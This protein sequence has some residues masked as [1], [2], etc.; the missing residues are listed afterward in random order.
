MWALFLTSQDWIP[1]KSYVSSPKSWDFWDV[2]LSF[3]LVLKIYT[4]F[5]FYKHVYLLW[6]SSFL[7]FLIHRIWNT[8]KWNRQASV[9]P[10]RKCQTFKYYSGSVFIFYRG[11]ACLPGRLHQ[12]WQEG[13]RTSREN[14]S[15]G[16]FRQQSGGGGC[17]PGLLLPT[18]LSIVNKA[19]GCHGATPGFN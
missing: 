5:H 4:G 18:E 2:T 7:H 1:R 6:P 14:P 16:R 15:L 10:G 17:A 9:L 3:A 12:L 13:S 11:A 19:A 8:F